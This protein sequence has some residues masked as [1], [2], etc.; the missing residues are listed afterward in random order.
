[1]CWGQNEQIKPTSSSRAEQPKDFN[2]QVYKIPCKKKE[3]KEWQQEG[4]QQSNKVMFSNYNNKHLEDKT[5]SRNNQC[6][7][8]QIAA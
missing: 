7:T 3:I 6:Q 4:K 2:N 5:H 1:M 8:H